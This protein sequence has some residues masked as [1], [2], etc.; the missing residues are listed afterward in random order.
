[1]TSSSGGG[2]GGGATT[3]RMGGGGPRGGGMQ[4]GQGRFNFS[5][6]HTYRLQDEITIR[7]GLPVLD[8]LD[9]AATG[10]RGGQPRNEIQMQ[11]GV[12]KSGMGAFMNANWRD[13]T[14]IDGG[15]AGAQDL[16]FSDQ[17]T[18]GLNVFADL[19]SRPT[20]VAK[21]PWLKGARV[22]IGVENLFDSRLEVRDAQGNTPLSYQSDYLDPLGRTFRISLR[23]ILF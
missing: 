12:F 9:G 15:G 3:F 16:T 22:N 8:L 17:T 14:R 18:V 2:G 13:S 19:S 7:D 20:W 6:Y 23:K 21:Y 1:I 4:A 10:S 11:T 5:L